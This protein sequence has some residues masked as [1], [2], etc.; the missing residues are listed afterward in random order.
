MAESAP[1]RTKLHHGSY[2]NFAYEEGLMSNAS[3]H[4][5]IRNK[6]GV[7]R[8]NFLISNLTQL[9]DINILEY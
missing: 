5:G 4:A 2:F 1:E 3:I 9:V 8:F 6:L 7:K